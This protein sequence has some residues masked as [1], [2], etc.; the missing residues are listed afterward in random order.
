[1][2][3]TILDIKLTCFDML[4]L[5]LYETKLIW[6]N[7]F[8]TSI[9]LCQRSFYKKNTFSIF[10]CPFSRIVVCPLT[11]MNPPF[12]VIWCSLGHVKWFCVKYKCAH[13][14]NLWRICLSYSVFNVFI[15]FLFLFHSSP[16]SHFKRLSNNNK[17][18]TKACVEFYAI[19][20]C[21]QIYSSF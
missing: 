15:Y 3:L 8:L 5:K 1:M 19:I 18:I 12:S 17:K 11:F 7:C 2:V 10:L 4:Y 20:P 16:F 13:S 6:D 9:Y 14:K 21:T